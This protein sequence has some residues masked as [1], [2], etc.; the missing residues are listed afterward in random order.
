MIALGS[1]HAGFSLKE[2]IKKHLD[3]TGVDYIDV[4]CYSP[5][6]FDYAISAQKACD[7][8]VACE[9]LSYSLCCVSGV[10]ISMSANKV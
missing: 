9:C 2:E 3:E 1:D 7:K 6:R 4:G 8:V 5:E 10:V